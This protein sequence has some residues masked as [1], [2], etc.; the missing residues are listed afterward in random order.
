MWEPL[1]RHASSHPARIAS[2]L[3]RLPQL[4]PQNAIRMDDYTGTDNLEVMAEAVNYNAFLHAQVAARAR[5]GDRIL[6]FGAGIGTFAR[7]LARQGFEVA[8]LEPDPQQ[9]QGLAA[10]GLHVVGD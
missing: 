3:W 7:E 9:A 2:P 1:S 6:D 10:D 8:C 5:A 4:Q